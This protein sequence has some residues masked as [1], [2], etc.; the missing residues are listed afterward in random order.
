MHLDKYS[1]N[2]MENRYN[3][4]NKKNP[5]NCNKCTDCSKANVKIVL[6]PMSLLPLPSKILEKII[7]KQYIT[8]L[9]EYRYINNKQYGF[10]KNKSTMTALIDFTD[11]I[12][13]SIEN[14]HPFISVFI[15]FQKAF[16]RLNH[17]IL[18]HKLSFFGFTD[19]TIKFF[20]NYLS[21]R[22]QKTLI[23][24]KLSDP[25]TITHGVPQGSNLGPL[26]FLLYI[27]DINLSINNSKIIQFA[28]DTTLYT[29][30]NNIETLK[31][32]IQ[33]D[34]IKINNWCESNNMALNSKK[35]KIMTFGRKKMV[36]NTKTIEIEINNTKLQMV[37]N[38]RYLGMT[39][40]ECLNY[41]N[42]IKKIL[43]SV[44]HKMYL[45]KRVK[46]Y[47]TEKSCLLIYKSFI[48]PIIEYGNVLY[49]N[50]NKSNLCKLQRIQNHCIKVCL[51]LD[52]RSDTKVIHE[53]AKLN[54]LEDRREKQIL[55]LMF[56]RT[57]ED[58][59]LE[60]PNEEQRQTRS[61]SAPKLKFPKFKNNQA[62]KAVIYEGSILWNNLPN[63]IK[64]SETK[65]LF[66]SRIDSHFKKKL[67]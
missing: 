39:L 33:N 2:S 57:K 38:Y 63:I 44:A 31:Y 43:S 3:Y 56:E 23:N 60:K 35:T 13:T 53:K 62:K 8:H 51:N 41:N 1:T 64:K 58:I 66:N 16:D 65:K 24:N 6:R 21:N 32:N 42:Y 54:F 10:Q 19:N 15:D 12:Y 34:L 27:N 47:L 59:Y 61:M 29:S 28:D 52:P 50:T 22:T 30:H 48:L 7:Y 45:M 5:K 20:V 17:S 55:K 46:Q 25:L 4:S 40:D 11:E 36:N 67:R 18:L 37:N 26:L 49:R 14:N 9:N